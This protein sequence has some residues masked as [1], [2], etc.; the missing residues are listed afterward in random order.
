MKQNTL[1]KVFFQLRLVECRQGEFVIVY[2]YC[3]QVSTMFPHIPLNMIVEDLNMTRSLEVTVENIL[4][5]R[6]VPPQPTLFITE[7]EEEQE[8][9]ST[10][11]PSST[12]EQQTATSQPDLTLPSPSE[13]QTTEER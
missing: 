10:E 4:D 13:T 3:S 12:E 2:H 9:R 7:E 8:E 6:L 11:L 5:E 1:L